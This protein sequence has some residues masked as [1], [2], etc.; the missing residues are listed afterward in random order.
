[1][2]Y[3][4]GYQLPPE[5]QEKFSE[6]VREFRADVAELYFPWPDEPTCRA[7]LAEQRGYV[8]W[9]APDR[10]LEDLDDIK[11]MGVRLDLLFNANCYGGKAVSTYLENRVCSIVEY[12][13]AT[14]GGVE[15]LT[16]ASPAIARIVR[17]NF[18]GIEIRASVN[19]R[20][21]TVK[22]MEYL[23][24]L[25]DSFHM[26]RDYNRDFNR[27]AELKDWADANGKKLIMLANS[28]CMR[29]CSGQT[30]HDNMVAHER[31]IDETSNMAGWTPHTC[32]RYLKN[33]KNWVSILQNTWVRP[34][35]IHH[36][37]KYF[38]IVKIATRM[39]S[40]PAM[41]IRAY[42]E[43]KHM[44]S[45]LDL[46]EPGFG[47]ALAPYIIDNLKFPDDWFEK[48]SRCDK[49]CHKCGYC[50]SILQKVL[51]SVE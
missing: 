11:K 36:Y 21:G 38:D 22:G 44:G 42:V 7:A 20:V 1:M 8:D 3:A 46:C 9:S 14:I 45:L 16:C 25:F 28:G 2:K 51:V 26:Q 5:G 33:R 39:H 37:E 49:K 18:T 41:V 6:V 30:F 40:R 34:E 15:I 12:L 19:M 10:L 13:G 48:T 17:K 4:V 35:D 47:P 29:F 43:R 23:A 31:E 24:D 32:W 27:I 50:A